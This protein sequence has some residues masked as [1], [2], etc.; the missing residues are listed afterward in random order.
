LATDNDSLE[1]LDTALATFNNANVDLEFIACA[2]LWDVM[3]K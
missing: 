3:A 2:K 1:D